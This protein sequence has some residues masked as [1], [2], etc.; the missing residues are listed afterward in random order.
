MLPVLSRWA[1]RFFPIPKTDLSL[2]E[3]PKGRL[4]V[5]PIKFLKLINAYPL[6]E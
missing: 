5:T 6:A 1:A 3:K 4:W 2:K